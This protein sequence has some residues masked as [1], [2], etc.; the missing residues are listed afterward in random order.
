MMAERIWNSA[1]CWGCK[2]HNQTIPGTCK[3]FPKGIPHA[4]VSNETDHF[5]VL[6]G[7]LNDMV[8]E[9]KEKKED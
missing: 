9:P 2:H 5:T 3:A 1:L 4:I 8:Y 7:Q 6:E